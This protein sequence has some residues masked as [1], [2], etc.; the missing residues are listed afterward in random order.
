MPMIDASI[1]RRSPDGLI[2]VEVA[3]FMLENCTSFS[4]ASAS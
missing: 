4:P 3:A 1:I 2:V